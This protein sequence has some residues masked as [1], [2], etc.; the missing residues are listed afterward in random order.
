LRAANKELL[1]LYWDIG[2]SIHSKQESRGWGKSVVESLANDLQMEF[3]GKNGFSAQ[4]LWLMRQ[5][6]TQYGENI[7]LQ[8][9]VREIGWEA[10]LAKSATS[11]CRNQSIAVKSRILM[12][13]N[14][15]GRWPPPLLKRGGVRRRGLI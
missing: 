9:L 6:Y 4:N 15:S 3:P 7:K 2:K 13:N 1:E 11:G 12:N 14:P 5:F 10:G 8:P